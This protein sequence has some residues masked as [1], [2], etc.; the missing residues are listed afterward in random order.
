MAANQHIPT[1]K[2][3]GLKLKLASDTPDLPLSHV[4][5]NGSQNGLSAKKRKVS[6]SAEV[7]DSTTAIA[8]QAKKPKKQLN[9]AKSSQTSAALTASPPDSTLTPTLASVE[10][11]ASEALPQDRTRV[12]ISSPTLK[13]RKSVSFTPETKT[14]DGDSTKQLYAAWLTQQDDDF[15]LTTAAQALRHVS[16]PKINPSTLPS[17][18]TSPKATQAK[19]PKLSK[20]RR[21]KTAGDASTLTPVT[22]TL[23]Y[24]QSYHTSRPT[25]KFNKSKQN[26]VLKYAF[27][28]FKIPPS[29]D[30]ALNAYMDGLEK[31]S[32]ARKRLREEALAIRSADEE[33]EAETSDDVVT[34]STSDDESEDS[35][36]DSDS[37]PDSDGDGEVDNEE[38]AEM[39]LEAAAAAKAAAKTAK[40]TRRMSESERKKLYRR[41]LRKYQIQLKE[42]LLLK[43]ERD[44]LHDP[45]W[46]D[47]LLKRKRAELVLW[48]I[49]EDDYGPHGMYQKMPPGATVDSLFQPGTVELVDRATGFVTRVDGR[50]EMSKM[51]N[52]EGKRKRKRKRRTGVPDDDSSSEESSSSD[53]EGDKEVERRRV[54]ARERSVVNLSALDEDLYGKVG[55]K[56]E[57]SE[58]EGGEG[59]GSGSGESSGSGDGSGES[60][61]ESSGSGSGGESGSDS[62]GGSD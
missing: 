12:S 39:V 50:A 38:D 16:P 56:K 11:A 35:N 30:P 24:L 42:K 17:T 9:S 49:G 51:V 27:D 60:D 47:R 1:W 22:A 20:K 7:G 26:Q 36:S 46:R 57:G 15:D 19:K 62:G 55:G 52:V 53:S 40:A 48:S 43:E 33:I 14:Q 21:S 54:E 13:K 44:K 31:T 34:E 3:L 45:S 10:L 18:T 41:A 29:Y 2:K 4:D 37:N 23:L 61:S 6:L 59:N 58:V 28:T 32:N 25:W 5:T 8:P